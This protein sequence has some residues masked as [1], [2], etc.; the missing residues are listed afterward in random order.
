MSWLK[1]LK[2]PLLPPWGD[3]PHTPRVKITPK[4]G[5]RWRIRWYT[6]GFK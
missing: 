2:T 5:H 4:R 6:T 3:L 1:L